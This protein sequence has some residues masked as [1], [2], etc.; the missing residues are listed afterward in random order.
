M[1]NISL[2]SLVEKR[3][4]GGRNLVSGVEKG[5]TGMSVLLKGKH[6]YSK[7]NGIYIR[8]EPGQLGGHGSVHNKYI[9]TIKKGE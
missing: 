2:F 6:C 4:N 3:Q 5:Q 7:C 9:Q 1:Q 8:P